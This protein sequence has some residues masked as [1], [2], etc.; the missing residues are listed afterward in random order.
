M[1][2]RKTFIGDPYLPPAEV[3]HAY[4]K[5][6]EEVRTE[7]T[8]LFT[9]AHGTFISGLAPIVDRNGKAVAI[10]HAD[11]GVDSYLDTV[12]TRTIK[13]FFVGLFGLF[14][15]LSVAWLIQKHFT[16]RI[17]S[18]LGA[19]EAIRN[20]EYNHRI[21]LIGRDEIAVVGTAM[22]FTLAKLQERF[23]MLKFLPQHTLNMISRTAQ[24]GGANLQEAGRKRVVVLETD[25][26]G[27]TRFSADRPPER[28]IGM[29]NR[30]LG[31]QAEL[32]AQHGGSIDKFM[33]DAVLAIFDGP[34]KEKDALHCVTRLLKELQLEGADDED[35]PLGIGAGLSV[36]E[37]VMG[38]MGSKDR[39]EYAVIGS[40]VNLAARMCGEAR[41][42]E[43]L[44]SEEFEAVAQELGIPL[45]AAESIGFKGFDDPI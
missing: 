21:E 5:V 42:W 20:Q 1:L 15:L 38:N 13:L 23:E 30:I 41:P 6:I 44:A 36:G 29:L 7:H 11:F 35:S 28:V 19:T 45:K 14:I 31:L 34:D 27:F 3:R 39:M 17:R 16:R 12:R 10:L 18:L 24:T 2:Q 9:D 4:R 40:T 32:I 43:V 8:S 26:R 33:G 25:I 37:V 22:N